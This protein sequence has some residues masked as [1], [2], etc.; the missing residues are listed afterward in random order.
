MVITANK[1]QKI[2]SFP[3]ICMQTDNEIAE[4]KSSFKILTSR[5]P[6]NP[7]IGL[8]DIATPKTIRCINQST[9]ALAGLWD[10]KRSDPQVESAC[11]PFSFKLAAFPSEPKGAEQP[12]GNQ[13][14]RM[15]SC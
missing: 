4:E 14:M 2:N 15:L 7:L 1:K 8:R 12:K 13:L 3:A 11:S 5:K 6:A 9:S 10:S